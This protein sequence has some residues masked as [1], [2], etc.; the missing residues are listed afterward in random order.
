LN[1]ASFTSP[2]K[3]RDQIDVFIAAHNQDAH[4]FK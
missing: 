1:G 2:Q 3:V 4:S